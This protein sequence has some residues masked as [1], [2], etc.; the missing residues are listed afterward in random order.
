MKAISGV[1]SHHESEL[2]EFRADRDLAIEREERGQ[3]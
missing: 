1:V 2:A 3:T